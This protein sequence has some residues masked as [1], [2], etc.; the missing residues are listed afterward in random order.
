V[1]SDGLD[2]G[3]DTGS[4]GRVKPGD[5]QH[6]GWHQGHVVTLPPKPAA[7]ETDFGRKSRKRS[8]ELVAVLFRKSESRI[9][10]LLSNH[11][12]M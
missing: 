6:N 3:S 12:V 4:G 5:G 10:L 11:N 7:G 9:Y 8:H 2:I 1:G